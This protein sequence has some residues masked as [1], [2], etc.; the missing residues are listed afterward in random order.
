MSCFDQ[1]TLRQTFVKI[2]SLKNLN[3]G[4]FYMTA[5]NE[6]STKR[7]LRK[8]AHE[9][10]LMSLHRCREESGN[11]TL[12]TSY[13]SQKETLVCDRDGNVTCNSF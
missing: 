13:Y 7:A 6:P 1:T 11:P 10:F 4:E 12:R 9:A 5:E 2:P 8:K 3:L